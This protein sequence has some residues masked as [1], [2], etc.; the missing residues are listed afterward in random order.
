MLPPAP[1]LFSTITCS[2]NC[3]ES[4][5]AVA[6]VSVSAGPPAA[7]GTTMRTGRDG[8]DCA[9]APGA[10]ATAALASAQRIRSRREIVVHDPA[11]SHLLAHRWLLVEVNPVGCVRCTACACAPP[12]LVSGR[13]P[14]SAMREDNGV[15]NAEVAARS[16]TASRAT[17]A[18]HR[19]HN[20]GA[21]PANAGIV[22]EVILIAQSRCIGPF[23]P[24]MLVRGEAVGGGS[25]RPAA[26]CLTP[27]HSRHL[28]QSEC[29]TVLG[30]RA[31]MG[32]VPD[33]TN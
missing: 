4:A 15:A 19:W 11:R 32:S 18:S 26:T 31:V 21:V 29:G 9:R 2:F 8:N 28:L 16:R 3:T 17:V 20:R 23:A 6:R 5:V 30:A 10:S 1:G 25:S 7:N 27:D 22:F 33:A 13:K 14:E 12:L 24:G